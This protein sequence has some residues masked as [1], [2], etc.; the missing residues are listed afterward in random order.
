[1]KNFA[2]LLSVVLAIA[3]C[4]STVSFAAFT[5]EAEIGNYNEATTVLNALGIITGY[6]DGSFG[7]NK[8]ITRAEFAK[9]VNNP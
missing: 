1:M 9:I 8:T 4:L 2:K 5:D 7:P 3:L 6:E